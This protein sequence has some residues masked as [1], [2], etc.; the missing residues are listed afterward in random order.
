MRLDEIEQGTAEQQRVDRLKAD[1]ES[2]KDRAKQMNMKADANDE[3]LKMQG[4]KQK[5]AQLQRQRV[6]QTIKPVA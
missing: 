6:R 1:A 4:S 5:L 2:A 3:R